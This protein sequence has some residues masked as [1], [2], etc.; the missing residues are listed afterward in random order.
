MGILGK[1][2]NVSKGKGVW[3]RMLCVYSLLLLGWR[4]YVDDR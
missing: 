2:K 1:N 4:M 3:S